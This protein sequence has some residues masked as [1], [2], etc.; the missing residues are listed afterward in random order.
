MS[1]PLILKVRLGE[2]AAF[3]CQSSTVISFQEKQYKFSAIYQNDIPEPSVDKLT[4]SSCAL[5]LIGPTGSGKTTT[6]KSILRRKLDLLKD[7]CFTVCEVKENRQLIDLLDNGATKKYLASIPL[8]KQ[9]KRH[10]LT[11]GAIKKVFDVRQTGSTESNSESSRSCLIV[12]V[13]EKAH[14]TTIVDM[15]GNEKF[16]QAGSMSNAFANT[17]VSSITQLLLSKTTKTRSS[18]LVTN[19]IFNRSSVTKVKFILHLHQSG[20]PELIKSS[21]YNIV[22]VIKNFRIADSCPSTGETLKSRN[23]PNYARPT[24]ASASPRKK[25]AFKVVKPV[26]NGASPTQSRTNKGST[27]TRGFASPLKLNTKG[28]PR[29]RPPQPRITNKVT[30]SLYEEQI[31]RLKESNEVFEAT[32]QQYKQELEDFRHEYISKVSEFKLHTLS[33]KSDGLN[34]LKKHLLSIKEN[35]DQLVCAHSSLKN[36]LKEHQ[37]SLTSAQLL[38]KEK[39]QESNERQSQLLKLK[40]AF[41]ELQNQHSV[42]LKSFSGELQKN[43]DLVL[44]LRQSFKEKSNELQ[45]LNALFSHTTQL[46]QETQTALDEK[47]QIMM[48]LESDLQH[49]E[50]MLSESSASNDIKEKTIESMR[51]EGATLRQEKES[52]MERLSAVEGDLRDYQRMVCEKERDIDTE[53][54]KA[55]VAEKLLSEARKSE[56]ASNEKINQ[57]SRTVEEMSC[58]KEEFSRKHN[59]LVSYNK[60]IVEKYTGVLQDSEKRKQELDEARN[61]L[62]RTVKAMEDFKVQLANKTE[63][64]EKVQ[65]FREWTTLD[66]P[67]TDVREQMEQMESRHSQAMAEIQREN[68]ELRQCLMQAQGSPRKSFNPAE[69][70]DD[71]TRKDFLKLIKKNMK[72]TSPS[73][74]NVLK[75]SNAVLSDKKKIKRRASSYHT[76]I[77]S[78]KLLTKA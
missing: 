56:R 40:D 51:I 73:K 14:T 78:P 34:P 45:R 38:A 49:K 9:L 75:E 65:Q 19:L 77:K 18:N 76:A 4:S 24:A 12:N 31:K 54:T 58:E 53:I 69:I 63:E 42:D 68:E 29:T 8:E 67:E 37:E 20:S 27:G 39:D 7:N 35:F 46:L 32:T 11:A 70:F 25:I 57:L 64:L 30:Q 62:S 23:V 50:T 48:V 44:E 6:L 33:L 2:K 16:S 72:N 47:S 55:R 3:D 71:S 74:A 26:R 21:L 10:K 61:E 17:N 15:M 5:V 66:T 43:T 13:H 59:E 60:Y 41:A 22:D 52:M 36:E 28:G 1:I